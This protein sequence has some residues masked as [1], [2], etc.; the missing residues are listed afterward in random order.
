MERKILIDGREVPFKATASTPR[1]YRQMFHKDFFADVSTLVK[2]VG[3]EL[4][5][6]ADM[7]ESFENIAFL[8]AKQADET[9]PDNPDDWLDGFTMLSIYDALPELV[10]LWLNSEETLNKTKKK[11][12]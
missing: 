2:S 12:E 7:L 11:Q 9:I 10:A 6:T 8:M 1:R 4:P 3:S 5:L